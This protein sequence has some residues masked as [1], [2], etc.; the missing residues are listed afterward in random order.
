MRFRRLWTRRWPGFFRV[1]LSAGVLFFSSV[2]RVQA[3]TFDFLP[4]K[5]AQKAQQIIAKLDTALDAWTGLERRYASGIRT[6]RLSVSAIEDSEKI[7]SLLRA[8]LNRSWTAGTGSSLA[9]V[10]EDTFEQARLLAYILEPRLDRLGLEALTEIYRL[11][12]NRARRVP[13]MMQDYLDFAESVASTD[14]AG[15]RFAIRALISL[16]PETVSL[17]LAP[18]DLARTPYA[19]SSE[20]IEKAVQVRRIRAAQ[21]ELRNAAPALGTPELP[22][23]KAECEAVERS[24]QALSLLDPGLRARIL[25]SIGFSDLRL[26]PAFLAGLSPEDREVWARSNGISLRSVSVLL[27]SPAVGIVPGFT[28]RYSVSS[29]TSISFSTALAELERD[30]AKSLDGIAL[31]T[32]LRDPALRLFLRSETAPLSLRKAVSEAKTRL[33]FNLEGLLSRNLSNGLIRVEILEV[34]GLSG[35]TALSVHANGPDDVLIDIKPGA[36]Q[37]AMDELVSAVS[38]DPDRI[39]SAL[40]LGFIAAPISSVPRQ[41]TVLDPLTTATDLSAAAFSALTLYVDHDFREYSRTSG[42]P[43]SFLLPSD[44]ADIRALCEARSLGIIEDTLV[45]MVLDR[46]GGRS[47]VRELWE[48]AFYALEA[49]RR[50]IR[51]YSGR[52]END[53][54][55]LYSHEN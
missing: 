34:P 9:R 1:T 24:V 3:A 29:E 19:G 25:D 18:D 45:E 7:R 28:N 33:A 17:K 55:G 53:R 6:A 11:V 52:D 26:L 38:R 41:V 2:P 37:S 35:F 27:A 23:T 4:I 8:G 16:D 21:E 12:W 49:A 43:S 5:D 36:V 42:I 31:L 20:L 51:A 30:T 50:A 40:E 15:L 44:L 14:S 48:Q 54:G 32:R 47:K 46:T 10:R 13:G 22:W 39:V